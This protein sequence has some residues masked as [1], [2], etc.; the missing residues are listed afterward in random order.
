MQTVSLPASSL[1]LRKTLASFIIEWL[2]IEL[3]VKPLQKKYGDEHFK[4]EMELFRALPVGTVGNEFARLLDENGLKPIPEHESHDLWHIITGYGMTSEE[5]ICMQ[6]FMYG[7]GSRSIFCVLFILSGL[8]LPSCW[9][10]FYI[11]YKRGKNNTA[12]L[13]LSIMD[14]YELNTN[15][16]KKKVIREE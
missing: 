15:S 1:S 6:A 10:N 5:E 8:L 9:K 2:K 12:V 13:G 3:I 7:N 4:K 14:C 16:L 11:A